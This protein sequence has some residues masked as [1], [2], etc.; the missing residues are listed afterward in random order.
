MKKPLK[1]TKKPLVP[2]IPLNRVPLFM[3]TDKE[4][5]AFVFS[6]ENIARSNG[7]MPSTT[8]RPSLLSL[9]RDIVYQLTEM[10]NR[11]PGSFSALISDAGVIPVIWVAGTESRREFGNLI[12]T[13][14]ASVPKDPNSEQKRLFA[15]ALEKSS[16]LERDAKR[17]RR[18][19][20]E[21][22]GNGPGG[23]PVLLD[24]ENWKDPPRI[25]EYLS[26]QPVHHR[27]D[28]Y[29]SRRHGAPDLHN[30]GNLIA[31]L[32]SVIALHL[33]K[34]K[35]LLKFDEPSA[36]VLNNRV[37]AL[38]RHPD[39]PQFT[40]MRSFI[41]GEEFKMP[42]TNPTAQ[43]VVSTVWR[44][45]DLQSE[46]WHPQQIIELRKLAGTITREPKKYEAA[47]TE[48]GIANRIRRDL[49]QRLKR[50]NPG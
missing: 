36:A 42:S 39:F 30:S 15:L 8:D 1:N 45:L 26:A 9:T 21:Q 49:K 2:L 35:R 32:F 27:F 6:C 22:M 7:Y 10:I 24:T 14:K 38:E 37:D 16:V 34:G 29:K 4:L 13:V 3:I 50:L 44:L 19:Y 48:Y 23:W 40:W 28:V 18:Y 33:W 25:I 12:A 46:D 43:D 47:D 11:S 20:S 31:A 17:N 41:L 5:K